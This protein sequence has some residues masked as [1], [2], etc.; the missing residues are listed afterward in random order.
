MRPPSA[1]HISHLQPDQDVKESLRA[2]LSSVT[3]IR[4]YSS[5]AEN[6]FINDAAVAALLLFLHSKWWF[7]H[8]K[9]HRASAV[10]S[11]Y[12]Y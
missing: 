4:L 11:S 3:I 10:L 7:L 9:K 6:I 2:R 8:I 5:E 1:L 12:C